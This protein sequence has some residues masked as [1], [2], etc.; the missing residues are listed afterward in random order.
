MA[1]FKGIIDFY[2]RVD[3]KLCH[4]KMIEALIKVG[5]FDSCESINR[6][7]MLENRQII[8]AH[9]VKRQEEKNLGQVS[10]FANEESDHEVVKDRLN[11]VHQK[12]FDDHEKLTYERELMGIYV[13]GHPLNNVQDIVSQVSSMEISKISGLPGT[14]KRD[15]T[16]AG[17]LSSYKKI[18][19]RKG[20]RMCFATLEDLSGKIECIIFPKTFAQYETILENE[21]MLILSGHIN[22]SEDTRKF[23]PNKIQPLK[24]VTEEKVVRVQINVNTEKTTP[25]TLERF[26]QIIL[27]YRGSVPTQLVFESREGLAKMPLGKD[28]LVNPNPQMAAQINQLFNRNSVQFIVGEKI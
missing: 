23:F 18:L 16:L 6:K 13:S 14:G 28:F 17:M 22:L 19:T 7:T 24:N 2:E 25:Q 21:E 3:L 15:M 1:L 27:S 26:K 11:I 9:G 10:L 5:A 8:H 4:R 12:D 20:D